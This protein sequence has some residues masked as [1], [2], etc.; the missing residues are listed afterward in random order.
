MPSGEADIHDGRRGSSRSRVANSRSPDLITMISRLDTFDP[1]H[2]SIPPGERAFDPR[3]ARLLALPSPT[4]EP[5]PRSNGSVATQACV[6]GTE[7]TIS[8]D[9]ALAGHRGRLDPAPSNG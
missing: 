4:N 3:H 8:R 6:Q 1:G 5:L 9:R 7:T 2:P